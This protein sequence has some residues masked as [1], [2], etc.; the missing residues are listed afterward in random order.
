[1]TPGARE[2]EAV[3]SP[4]RA[5]RSKNERLTL[6]LKHERSIVSVRFLRETGLETQFED[7]TEYFRRDAIER[8]ERGL[9]SGNDLELL[10]VKHTDGIGSQFRSIVV[11]AH[12]LE[13]LSEG[14]NQLL[15]VID[16]TVRDKASFAILIQFRSL[17]L[18]TSAQDARI[19]VRH[20]R[21][22][23]HDLGQTTSFSLRR[24]RGRWGK[25]GSKRRERLN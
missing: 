20:D 1:M 14:S 2:S 19:R 11:S 7:M 25:Q 23:V 3:C 21:F 16:Y 17:G 13:T 9:A 15:A 18:Q 24:S 5:D 22:G 8:V 12:D 4:S 6:T 10:V